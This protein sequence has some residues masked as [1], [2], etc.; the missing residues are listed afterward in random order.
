MQKVAEP[1]RSTFRMPC[2]RSAFECVPLVELCHRKKLMTE[3]TCQELRAKLE[4][5]CKML[6]APIKGD[7]MTNFC[8]AKIWWAHLESNQ[9]PTGYE[10]VALTN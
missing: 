7:G 2:C 4:I 1:S 8:S 6:T 9:G 10:P 5:I 3:Q